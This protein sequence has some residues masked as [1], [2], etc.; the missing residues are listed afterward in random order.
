VP[1]QASTIK[2]QAEG[3]NGEAT[4]TASTLFIK[5]QTDTNRNMNIF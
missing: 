1:A 5:L 2:L 3:E 4:G